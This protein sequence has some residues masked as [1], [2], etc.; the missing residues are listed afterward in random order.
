MAGKAL[1]T[2]AIDKSQL[3]KELKKYRDTLVEQRVKPIM[4]RLCSEIR[5]MAAVEYGA[6]VSVTYEPTA[7]SA[8]DALAYR[9]IANGE[10]VV[11]LEFGAGVDT[12]SG[13]EYAGALTSQTG[14][15]VTPG[16]YSST[17]GSGQFAQYGWWKFGGRYYRG[18]RPLRALLHAV[19]NAKANW[20]KV[21]SKE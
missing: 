20:S 8:G 4:E 13:H 2:L 15:N 9:I 16:S 18:V 7:P 5:D 10:A 14:I 17:E 3:V 6:A 11:F 12:D 19:Q 1:I 21:G